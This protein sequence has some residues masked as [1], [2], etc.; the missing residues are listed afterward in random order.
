MEEGTS[1]SSTNVWSLK[2]ETYSAVYLSDFGWSLFSSKL[3]G[4]LVHS[5]ICRDPGSEIGTWK[6][7]KAMRCEH[8]VGQK[9]C[10]PKM[11]MVNKMY[12]SD[13]RYQTVSPTEDWRAKHFCML[14]HVWVWPF[15][16]WRQRSWSLSEVR[17]AKDSNPIG[18][19]GLER[20][21]SASNFCYLTK[22]MISVGLQSMVFIVLMRMGPRKAVSDRLIAD[23]RLMR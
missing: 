19:P 18:Y 12:V 7:K 14:C 1:K 6:Y 13:S 23:V 5:D 8:N 10:R 11:M 4:R 20:D 17:C 2:P 22:P 15:E 3:Y 21:E 9:W 16:E